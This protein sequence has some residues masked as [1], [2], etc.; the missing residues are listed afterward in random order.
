MEINNSHGLKLLS[1]AGV[2]CQSG[3]R[4]KGRRAAKYRVSRKVVQSLSQFE[5]S[6]GE[7]DPGK[8]ST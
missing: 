4:P 3:D 2:F 7:V 5:D 6:P 1:D 8:K